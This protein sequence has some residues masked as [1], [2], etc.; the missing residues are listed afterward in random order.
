MIDDHR[1]NEMVSKLGRGKMAFLEGI[2]ELAGEYGRPVNIEIDIERGALARISEFFISRSFGNPAIVMDPTTYKVAGEKV[3]ELLSSKGIKNRSHILKP[4]S[5]EQII[6]DE[7]TLVQLFME[8]TDDI[9][10]LVAVGSGTIHDVVR[11]VS[12]KMNKPFISVPTAA[13][14]D[15][16]TS[17]G[18]PLILRGVKQT[19]QVSAP[20]AVFADL[21]ILVEA[22]AEMTAAGFGDI[23]GKYTSLF[24]WKISHLIGQE[25]F[26]Q[27]A[28]DITRNL[29]EAC[30]LHVE[31]IANRDAKGIKILMQ[32]LIESGLVMLLLGYSRPASGGEHHLSHYW[33]ME[34][35]RNEAS[36]LLHGAKVGVATAIIADL[37]KGMFQKTTYE[38]LVDSTY[39]KN[40]A[41]NLETIREFIKELPASEKLKQLLKTVGGPSTSEELGVEKSLVQRSL[42]EAYHLRDRCTGLFLINQLKSKDLSFPFHK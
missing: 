36:Q 28:A 41:V 14:V 19:V 4:N 27:K 20:I 12:F 8:I 39:G 11:F 21:D 33:E 2:Q 9:D 7:Q 42:N 29:L 34:F 5:K 15:G 30:V 10:V 40:M 24:D 38:K 31:E 3:C 25:P 16:F 32:S 22:P 17:R 6:A 35:L 1:L 13:S 23:L 37:Y 26:D 18:A